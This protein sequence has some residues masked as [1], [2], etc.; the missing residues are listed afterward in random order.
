MSEESKYTNEAYR[1]GNRVL[2]V[3]ERIDGTVYYHV[4]NIDEIYIG[5][6]RNFL[7]PESDFTRALENEAAEPFDVNLLP[8]VQEN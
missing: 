1:Q 7:M 4:Q 2:V 5:F 8:A 6:N 3:H